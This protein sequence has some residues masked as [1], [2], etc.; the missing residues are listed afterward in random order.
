MKI[1]IKSVKNIV[2]Y[3]VSDSVSVPVRDS[4]WDSVSNKIDNI[5]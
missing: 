1:K 3:S 4:V 2:W 5:N